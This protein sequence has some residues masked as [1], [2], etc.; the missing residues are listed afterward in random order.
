[1]SNW[2]ALS[3]REQVTFDDMINEVP[4]VLDRHDLE[5][6]FYSATSLEEQFSGEHVFPLGYIILIQNQPVVLLCA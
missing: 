2:S 5:L 6:H 3:R 1:M 4:F